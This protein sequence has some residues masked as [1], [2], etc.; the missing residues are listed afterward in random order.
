MLSVAEASYHR[1]QIEPAHALQ[2]ERHPLSSQP[3]TPPTV[4][5]L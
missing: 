3:A 1:R 2:W 4:E 5:S